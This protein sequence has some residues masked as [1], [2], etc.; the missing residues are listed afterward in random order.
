[1]IEKARRLSAVTNTFSE[2]YDSPIEMPVL[3]FFNFN[4]FVTMNENVTADMKIW[5]IFRCFL[6]AVIW[7]LTFPNF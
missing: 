6:L 3:F 4:L 1:M 5:A 2:K 7:F